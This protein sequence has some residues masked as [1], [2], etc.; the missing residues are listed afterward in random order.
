MLVIKHNYR[1]RCEYTISALVAGLGLNVGIVCIQE[2]FL[3]KKNLTHAG[4][5]LYWPVE[6][7]ERKDNWVFIAVRKDLLNKILFQKDGGM[8]K[9]PK[10]EKFRLKPKKRMEKI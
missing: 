4:F 9:W 10:Q 5:N 3:E 1:K 6:V 7:R 8:I 2:P